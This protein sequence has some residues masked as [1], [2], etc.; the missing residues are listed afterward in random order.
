[1]GRRD[2]VGGLC[3]AGHQRTRFGPDRERRIRRRGQ[4]YYSGCVSLD[5]EIATDA[6][7]DVRSYVPAGSLSCHH[8]RDALPRNANPQS[9]ISTC[10]REDGGRGSASHRRSKQVSRFTS[11]PPRIFVPPLDNWRLLDSLSA[12]L[13]LQRRSA[14]TRTAVQGIQTNDR[15]ATRRDSSESRQRQGTRFGAGEYNAPSTPGAFASRRSAGL[16]KGGQSTIAMAKRNR[17]DRIVR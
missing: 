6:L 1:M 15:G 8:R 5:R 12:G 16:A 3:D 13:G 10:A 2:P 11:A 17:A 9:R 7:E 4:R 14:S